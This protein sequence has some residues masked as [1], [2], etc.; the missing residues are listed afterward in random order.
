MYFPTKKEK[1]M[2]QNL[3]TDNKELT[4]TRNLWDD[5]DYHAL[6]DLGGLVY[7]SNLLGRDRTVANIFGG[8]TSAKL[9]QLDYAGRNTRVMYVKASG[10]DLLNMNAKDFAV[11]RLDEMEPLFAR[12]SMTDEDMT[13]YLAYTVFEPGRP[14]QSIETLLHTFVPYAHVDHTHPDAIISLACTSA[15]EATARKL[16]GARMGWVDYIQPGFILSRWIGQSVQDNP[17]IECV[18]MGKHGLVTWGDDSKSCYDN[19]I[20]I[21]QEA[22]DYILEQRSG[23]AVFGAV[24]VPALDKS[25]RQALVADILPFVRAQVSTKRSMILTY[26]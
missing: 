26:D 1:N 10:S 16:F 15:G 18:I 20:R 12:E 25:A 9:E 11:L 6:P 4:I 22:E 5:N 21:I 7:R 24:K 13:D 8:N 23:K 14:R 19:T 2:I 3:P 17:H